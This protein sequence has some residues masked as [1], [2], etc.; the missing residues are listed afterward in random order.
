MDTNNTERSTSTFNNTRSVI[1]CGPQASNFSWDLNHTTIPW[2][3]A[4]ITSIAS[5]ATV[6]LNTLVIIAVNQKTELKKTSTLLLSS[7]AVADLLVG[8]IAMPLI[9]AADILI[10][11]QVSYSGF[12]ALR[13]ATEF[14]M[15]SFIWPSLYHLTLMAWERYVAIRKTI[16]YRMIVT[17]TRLKKLAI[18]AWV[19]GTLTSFPPIIMLETG[20]DSN[21]K[22]AWHIGESIVATIC[23]IIISYFYIMVY[24]AVRKRNINEITQVDVLVKTKLESK[25]AVTTALITGALILSFVPKIIAGGLGEVFPV[26][27]TGV[28]FRLPEALIQLN[29]LVN[30]LLYVYRDRRFRKAVLELLRLQKPNTVQSAAGAV[31]FVRDKDQSCS[32]RVYPERQKVHQ[33]AHLTRA[34]SCDLSVDSEYVYGRSSNTL[35][36]RSMSV[37]TLHKCSDSINGLHLQQCSTVAKTNAII[38]CESNTRQQTKNYNDELSKDAIMP[39]GTTHHVRNM[40]RAKSWEGNRCESLLVRTVRRPATAP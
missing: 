23:L 22:E 5:L 36:K 17:R 9:V 31:R 24:F 26:F 21:I 12:C 14:F 32:L 35:L 6:L 15:F 34:V 30:P 16:H 37:P 8:A 25:L 27:R 33:H 20:V 7:M 39:Q 40:P 11:R 3:F 4:P 28:A 10:I 2:I 29:S 18:T 19:L 1:Q 13:I 38:H